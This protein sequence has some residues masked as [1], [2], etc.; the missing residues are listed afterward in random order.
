MKLSC[1]MVDILQMC[2]QVWAEMDKNAIVVVVWK[3]YISM[4]MNVKF[5]QQAFY[6]ILFII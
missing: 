6:N 4:L 2:L 5:L 1:N 3:I